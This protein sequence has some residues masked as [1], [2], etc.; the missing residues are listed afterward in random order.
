MATPEE[1][2]AAVK[3]VDDFAGNPIVGVVAELL[4]DLEASA[5]STPAKEARVIEIKET[6]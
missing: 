5:V 1:I 2:K 4:K 6:R 3:I